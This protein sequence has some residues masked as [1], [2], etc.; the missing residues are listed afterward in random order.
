MQLKAPRGEGAEALARDALQLEA[1]PPGRPLRA[2]TA[3]DGGGDGGAHRALG[4]VQGV[5]ELQR[6]A[7]IQKAHGVAQNPCIQ[8]LGN[9]T[10]ALVGQ[11]AGRARLDLH[12]QRIEVEVVQMRAAAPHLAQQVGAA[13]DLV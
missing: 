1:Q 11:A 9:G 3:H 8:A 5:G 7:A 2:K 13:D 6:L 4:V 10:P 12:Q